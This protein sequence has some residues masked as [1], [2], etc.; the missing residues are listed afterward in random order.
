MVAGFQHVDDALVC[1]KIFCEE[2][3]LNG[4]RKLWPEDVGVSLEGS[5]SHIPFLHV[6]VEI[7]NDNSL[8]PVLITPAAPN[9]DFARG[10]DAYPALS[11]LSPFFH[12]EFQPPSILRNYFFCKLYGFDQVFE[13]RMTGV[14]THV[15]ALVSEAILLHWPIRNI[16]RL[17]LAFP[18]SVHSDF[19]RLIRTLGKFLRCLILETPIRDTTRP[20]RDVLEITIRAIQFTTERDD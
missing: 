5:G 6:D 9:R 12:R 2:C 7:L 18:Q 8:F 13:G 16:S 14:E 3:L 17:C 10:L 15:A 4:V 19:A 20:Y 11:K 1:S